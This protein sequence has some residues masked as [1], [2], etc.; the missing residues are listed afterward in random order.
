[1]PYFV[2]AYLALAYFLKFWPFGQEWTAYVYP[3]KTDM[4]IHTSHGPFD[5]LE[6]CIDSAQSVIF[7]LNKSNS[8]SYE[9]GLNCE[10]NTDY[11]LNV[12]EETAK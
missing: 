11:G 12:C 6:Q 2:V 1:M 3:K 10:F 8:A 7:S 4:S 9:C 5:S